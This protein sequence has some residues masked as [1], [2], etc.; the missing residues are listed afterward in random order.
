M[1]A[2]APRL[3]QINHAP[4]LT[5]PPAAQAPRLG[6]HQMPITRARR[7]TV[8]SGAPAD[9]THNADGPICQ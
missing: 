7:R 8:S 9:A 2:G 1:A 5:T 6:H 4:A 3:T